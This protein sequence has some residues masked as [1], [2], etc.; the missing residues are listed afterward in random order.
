MAPS[1]L[2]EPFWFQGWSRFGLQKVRNGAKGGTKMVPLGKG[3]LKQCHLKE[4][5]A[6]TAP[7]IR[8]EPFRTFF[9]K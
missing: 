5:G 1:W 9:F 7:L 3:E 6:K 8:M 2:V 4:G